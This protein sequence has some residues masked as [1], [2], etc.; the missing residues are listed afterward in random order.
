MKKTTH[1]PY[2]KLSLIQTRVNNKQLQE[3]VTKAHLYAEGNMS[4]YVRLACL[5]YRPIRKVER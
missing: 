5:N 4:E 3:I 1:K 2:T